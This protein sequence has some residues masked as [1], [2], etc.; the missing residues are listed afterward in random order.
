[1]RI[2]VNGSV[3]STVDWLFADVVVVVVD[4]VFDVD[5]FCTVDVVAGVLVPWD[6]PAALLVVVVLVFEQALTKNAST[7]KVIPP[8]QERRC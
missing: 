2:C 7:T 8:S 5:W 6:V 4:D 3:W 1:M